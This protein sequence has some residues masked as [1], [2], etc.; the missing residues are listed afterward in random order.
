MSQSD[1]DPWR[2]ICSCLLELPTYE[3]PQIVDGAGLQVDWALNDRENYSHNTRRAAYR[4]RINAVY[5]GLQDSDKLRVA[6]IVVEELAKR[7]KK[8]ALNDGLS[9]IGWKVESGKLL[10]TTDTV[11]ELFFP[12]ESPHDA[13]VEIKGILRKPT[14]NLDII[15]PYMDESMFTVLGALGETA[16]TVHLLTRHI[17]NDFTHEAKKFV[18][19]H[20]NFTIEVRKSKQFHDRFIILDS[21]ECWHLGCSIKDAGKKAF[22]LSQ[23]EDAGNCQALITQLNA[24][25]SNATQILI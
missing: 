17:P 10:P 8:E 22:M 21:T 5:N 9:R 18:A 4:P 6:Y 16:M 12:Q 20:S 2:V 19:Q 23:I 24:T 1:L 15:D 13:Y 11:R 7:E 25:W 14:H 3:I